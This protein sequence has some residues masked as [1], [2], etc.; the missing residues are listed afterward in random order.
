MNRYIGANTAKVQGAKSWLATHFS[1]K[2]PPAMMCVWYN[3]ALPF[4]NDLL[5]RIIYVCEAG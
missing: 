5:K 2:V 3:L 4:A 1:A